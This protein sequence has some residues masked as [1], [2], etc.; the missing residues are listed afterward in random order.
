MK[1]AVN[2][3]SYNR[4]AYLQEVLY[5][6]KLNDL[7]NCDIILW[8]DGY[9]RPESKSSIDATAYDKCINTFKNIFPESL[10]ISNTLNK[11]VGQMYRDMKDW[12]FK[13][14]QAGIFL[15]DDLV[16]GKNYISILK[17]LYSQTA[18]NLQVGLITA[19][20]PD[21]LVSDVE[22]ATRSKELELGIPSWGYLLGKEQYLL[23][24]DILE[25]EYYPLI[26]NQTYKHRDHNLI[27][28]KYV[29]PNGFKINSTSQ[30]TADTIAMIRS[31]QIKLSTVTR[32]ARYIGAVGEH[33]S[34][35]EFDN[36]YYGKDKIF[37]Y[38]SIPDFIIPSSNRLAEINSTLRKIGFA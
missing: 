20:G 1:Y 31:G 37:Q 28:N 38:D 4:P 35:A 13:R 26:N 24:K 32:N 8:Q 17:K 36:G 21:R 25:N 34:Q 27:L 5:S 22:Q 29:Y 14:F 3:L 12:T 9:I 23:R 7:T 2:I 16:L 19:Y 10:I 6:L 33:F 30:D 18:D 15:E 11:G